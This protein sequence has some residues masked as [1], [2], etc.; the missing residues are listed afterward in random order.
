MYVIRNNKERLLRFRN[1]IWFYSI[2]IRQQTAILLSRVR[3]IF[4]FFLRS[5]LEDS[6][7]VTMT[8]IPVR[9]DYLVK[10]LKCLVTQDVRP[11]EIAI[12]V[13]VNNATELKKKLR[14]LKI[15]SIKIYEVENDLGP[16]TKLIP[17]L[18][19]Q[20][21][22]PVVIYL[23]DDVIYPRNALRTLLRTLRRLEGQV[24][25]ANWALH[26]KFDENRVPLNYKNW[27]SLRYSGPTPYSAM[28]LGVGGVALKRDLAPASI[29]ET[30]RLYELTEFTDDHWYWAH[31]VQADIP[32]VLNDKKSRIPITWPGSQNEALW[33][34]ENVE[35]GRKDRALRKLMNEFPIFAERI[36]L[37]EDF[38]FIHK[39]LEKALNKK[40]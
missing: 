21:R 19:R 15:D 36:Q 23:D 34:V 37:V 7:V 22:P 12:Y 29:L 14:K 35:G 24:V 1:L 26:C 17:E 10:T 13:H 6:V 18:A 25:V 20:N 11:A 9:F 28:A 33:R 31:F 32:L 27:E 40:I 5:Q 4:R 8:S 3:W 2:R 30:E 38:D 16:A 39:R